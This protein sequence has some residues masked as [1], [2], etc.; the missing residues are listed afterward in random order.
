[1]QVSLFEQHDGYRY[2]VIAT[3]TVGGQLQ[4]LEARHRVHARVEDDV[5]NAKATGLRRLP[6]TV[7]INEAWC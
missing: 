7:G 4:R 6:S 3:N 5:R 2:Q 1:M